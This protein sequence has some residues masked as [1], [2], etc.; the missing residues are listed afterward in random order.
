MNVPTH[1]SN[2]P[3]INRSTSGHR[4]PLRSDPTGRRPAYA[5]SAAK[6]P[7]GPRA[8]AS[9]PSST[10]DVYAFLGGNA[11]L[12]LAMWIR[13]GGLA[14][15]GDAGRH[16]DCDGR[17][18]GAV[19]HVP[20]PDPARPHVPQPLARPGLRPGPTH[21]RPPLGRLRRDLAAG[22]PL[23]LHHGRLRHGRRQRPDRRERS[24]CWALSVRALVGRRAGALHCRRH[25]FRSGRPPQ[26]LVRNL[27]RDPPLHVPRHRPRVP[28]PADRRHR[29]R[30]DRVA[31][32][33]WIA[34]YVLA[35][36]SLA[37]FRFGQP[38]ATLLAAS[39]ARR[40]RRGRGRR[41]RLDLPDRQ[42]PRPPAG[43]SRPVVP[44]A[45]HDRTTAGGGLIRSPFRPPRTAATCASRSRTWATTPASSRTSTS[46]RRSSSRARTASSPAPRG[47]RPESCSSPAGSASRRCGPCSKSCPPRAAT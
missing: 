16:R 18:R 28:A 42:G 8:R 40:Q 24:P 43:P 10:S 21:R 30:H 27:V 13:H 12:I 4:S 2:G 47:P 5:A 31:Q 39:P 46:G 33:Y 1:P 38:I 41:S 44:A 14:R 37:V 32:A 6:G 20:G 34:L 19:R 11:L 35:F 3:G 25:H 23:H 29:L 7:A 15:T 17:D 22:R 26:G 36:G 45:V 9:G